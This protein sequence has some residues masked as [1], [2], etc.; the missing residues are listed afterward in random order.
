MEGNKTE[1]PDDPI[2][3]HFV[4]DDD[5]PVLFGHYWMLGEPRILNRRASRLDFSVANDGFL[6]AYRW[7]GEA[8]LKDQHLVWATA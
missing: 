5:T 4:Y 6:T 2:P 7:S 3:T 8:H 1:L